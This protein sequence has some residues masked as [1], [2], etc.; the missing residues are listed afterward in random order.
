MVV[1]GTL[2]LAFGW[3]GFNAGSTLALT[4]GRTASVAVCTM[5]AS[6]AGM[7]SS[8]LYMWAVFGKPDPTMACNGMLA[9]LVAITA[10]CAFVNPLGSVII[11]GLAGVLVIGSV[12]FVEKV[13]KVDDPVGAVS[14]HGTCGAFGCLC[15]GLFADGKYGAGWNG[16]ADKTPLGLFY[17][18]G[19]EQLAAEAIGVLANIAWVFP[20]ALG[21]FWVCNKTMGL[22]VRAE[23]EVKGLDIPEMGVLG[24]VNEDVYAVEKAGQEHLTTYGPEVP[25]R[26]T[27]VNGRAAEKMPAA[28]RK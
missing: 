27:I 1:L 20:V 24:Y 15:I 28:T 7:L 10:P 14:V 13:L 11:G 9:G 12:L 23:D 2:I 16:V 21:F 3:F 6:A 26:I 22:R 8:I 25:S 18:G 17:G 4:D 5:L 19:V